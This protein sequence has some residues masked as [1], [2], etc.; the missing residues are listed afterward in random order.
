MKHRFIFFVLMLFIAMG[1]IAAPIKKE[2]KT[3]PQSEMKK[4]TKAVGDIILSENFSLWTDGSEES[5][6]TTID[7]YDED[8]EM[9]YDEFMQDSGWGGYACF[10]AGGMAFMGEDWGDGWIVSYIATPDFEPSSASNYTV[11]FKARSQS[12]SSAL[13]GLYFNWWNE[14]SATYEYGELEYIDITSEWEEY[15]IV[16]PAEYV[17]EFC[18]VDFYTEDDFVFIDDIQIILGGTTE[19]PVNPEGVVFFEDCGTTAPGSNPRPNPAAY[20]GWK[21]YGVDNSTFSG[22]NTDVRSTNTMNSHVWFTGNPSTQPCVFEINGINTS[23]YEN[24]MLSFK[25]A[26]GSG[27]GDVARD[28]FS[29]KAVVG[30]TEYPITLPNTTVGGAFST[31]SDLTG[32]PSAENVKLVFTSNAAPNGF[33][34]DDISLTGAGGSVNID[35]LVEQKDNKPTFH[36]SGNTL[37]VR[38]VALGSTIEVYNVAGQK[39]KTAKYFGGGSVSVGNLPKGVYIIRVNNFSTKVVK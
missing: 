37:S 20:T 29:I 35:D 16:C 18:Y 10:Q 28:Y 31:I 25:L 3:R 24:L 33:R 22:N 36:I 7:V 12:A 34:L 11:K 4:E 26:I 2:R 6:S 1:V 9:I 38:N 32:I 14:D 17:R 8:E 15:S 13:M 30:S 5:P 21:N 39:L 19:P 23:D 27:S